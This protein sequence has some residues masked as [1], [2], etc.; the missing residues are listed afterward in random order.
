M[1]APLLEVLIDSTDLQHGQTLPVL[2]HP[3]PLG[4]YSA[5][6]AAGQKRKAS[7]R[8]QEEPDRRS[9]PRSL[10]SSVFV[11]YEGDI[12]DRNVVPIDYAAQLFDRYNNH[13]CKHL[14]A[15]VFPVGHTVHDLRK[16]RPLLFLA[17]MAAAASENH[18]V[19][20]VLQRD[21]LQ[22]FAEKVIMTGEKSLEIVQAL[23][24]AVIWYCAP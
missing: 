17:V 23:Q 21:L 18:S 12:V 15:V 14:P 16:S 8:E 11:N 5:A 9:P 1:Q 2:M 20:R 7:Q 13:M 3:R 24:V 22:A 6:V 19:S 10:N 4:P